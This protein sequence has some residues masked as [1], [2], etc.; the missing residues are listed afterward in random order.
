[1]DA[2]LSELATALTTLSASNA[3]QASEIERLTEEKHAAEFGARNGRSLSEDAIA[4]IRELLTAHDVPVAAFIDDHVG[5]AIAQ[6]DEAPAGISRLT[7]AV[8]ERD[9]A[10]RPFGNVPL[11]GTFGGPLVGARALYEDGCDNKY[12]P[13]GSSLG[14]EP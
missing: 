8:E 3:S 9:K 2:V 5:N 11:V 14:H 13:D 12:P 7:R 1:V 4:A 6:R 10:L